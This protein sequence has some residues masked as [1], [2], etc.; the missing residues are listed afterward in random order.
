MENFFNSKEQMCF[1]IHLWIRY[2]QSLQTFTYYRKMEF[3]PQS[4]FHVVQNR[5]VYVYKKDQLYF[6]SF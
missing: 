4:K 2:S 6:H 3:K 5:I 1:K